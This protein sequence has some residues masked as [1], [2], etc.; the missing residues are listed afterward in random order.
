VKIAFV[1]G[2]YD[3]VRKIIDDVHSEH[4]GNGSLIW[5]RQGP[6][7][8]ASMNEFSERFFDLIKVA[9]S[10]LVLLAA[11]RGREY[12]V[13]S[14]EG[15]LQKGKEKR[16]NLTCELVPFKNA[17]DRDGVLQRLKDF[18]LPDSVAVDVATIRSKIPDGQVLCVSGD[19]KTRILEALIRASFSEEAVET[20]FCEKRIEGGRNSNL[21]EAIESRSDQHTH[22][23]Y[24][25]GGLRSMPP[26]VKRKFH[27]CYEAQNAAKVVQMFKDYI[28]EGSS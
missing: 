28:T 8:M 24:A 22:L 12:V 27:K 18:G 5:I 19:G 10:I 21:M 7:G 2:F 4:L 13:Q 16:E 9:D 6:N 20:C 25:W 26:K 15:I 3:P 11:P 1:A 17:G 14:V 23:I